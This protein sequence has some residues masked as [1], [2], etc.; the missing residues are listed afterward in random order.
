MFSKGFNMSNFV[1]VS[2]LTTLD[3]LFYMIQ[4][5]EIRWNEPFTIL[6]FYLEHINA[7]YLNCLSILFELIF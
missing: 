4:G 5:I 1:S 6:Q 3:S 2:N 7:D